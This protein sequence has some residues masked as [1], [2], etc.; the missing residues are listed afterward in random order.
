MKVIKKIFKL[1][2]FIGFIVM[3]IN[4]KEISNYIIS[5]YI[6]N[7]NAIVEIAKGEYSKEI[8]YEFVQITNDFSAKNY[9]HLLNIIYTILDSGNNEYSFYCDDS[10][11]ECLDVINDLIVVNEESILSDINNYV[12]PYYTYSNIAIMTNNYGKVTITINKQYSDEEI[13]YIEEQL[14]LIETEVTKD[15]TD[16]KDKILAVHDYIINNTKYDKNRANNMNSQKFADSRTHTAYGL[17]SEKKSL[18][19]GYSD[20]MSIYIHRLNIKNIRISGNNHVWNL[21]ELDGWKHLD[22]TWDDPVTNTGEDMLLHD[23]FLITTDELRNTD[24]VEHQFNENIYVEA[25]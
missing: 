2:V 7:K 22:A 11:K 5:N 13:K 15:L 23:Y 12:H 6:Y 1:F 4:Y 16:N 14:N 3:L 20:L 24:E 21:V 10:Y 9:E 19:G 25:K 8:D 17:L 18:C